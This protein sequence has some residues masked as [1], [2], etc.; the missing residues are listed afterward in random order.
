[1]VSR[2]SDY[3][4]E[5]RWHVASTLIVGSLALY[6]TTFTS[7]VFMPSMV[8]LCIASFFIF[9]CALF[10]SIPPT[11][12]SSEA[13]ATGIAVISSIGILGGFVSPTLIGWMKTATGSMNGGLLA[14]TVLV[15][16]GG[17]TLLL[18]VPEEALRVGEDPPTRLVD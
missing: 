2:S 16:V 11:Y 7:G 13:A 6:A 15:C 9:A 14:S 17:V 4:K 1:M 3:F 8:L 10:W 18:A 5:R 12:L